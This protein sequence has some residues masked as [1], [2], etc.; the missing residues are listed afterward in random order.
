MSDKTKLK[1]KN[2]DDKFLNVKFQLRSK[3][4]VLTKAYKKTYIY[5][6]IYKVHT[7]AKMKII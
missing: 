4:Q 2:K 7:Y 3:F 1:K 6:Y 5:T